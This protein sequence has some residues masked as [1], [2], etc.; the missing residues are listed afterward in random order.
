MNGLIVRS[1][2]IKRAVGIFNNKRPH[3]SFEMLTPNK[4]Y[5]QNKI[6][7]LSYSKKIRTKNY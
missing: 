3:I 5:M 4:M 7:K 2:G 1:V 6:R